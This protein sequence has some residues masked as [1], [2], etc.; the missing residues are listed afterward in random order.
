MDKIFRSVINCLSEE[1]NLNGETV[2]RCSNL[3]LAM[4]VQGAMQD[5]RKGD[6]RKGEKRSREPTDQPHGETMR[7]LR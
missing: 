6:D 2:L 5:D 1:D 4:T 3:Y 7:L